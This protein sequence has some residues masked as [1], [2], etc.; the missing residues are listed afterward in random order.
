MLGA[1]LP[2]L[3]EWTKSL[4]TNKKVLRLLS[5]SAGARQIRRDKQQAVWFSKDAD[6]EAYYLA[7]FN[8]SD[9]IQTIAVTA[10]EIDI[11]SFEGKIFEELWSDEIFH[12]AND[13]LKMQV[14]AHGAK[15]FRI[16]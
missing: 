14:F 6:Q 16:G 8:L 12:S 15:L 4:I 13:I 11:N 9:E 3:D 7:V 10:E 1:E 2:R 5:K